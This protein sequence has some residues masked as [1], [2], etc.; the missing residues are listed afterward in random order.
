MQF[1]QN[2]PLYESLNVFCDT[3]Q[4]FVENVLFWI[5]GLME[6]HRFILLPHRRRRRPPP[7]PQVRVWRLPS[8]SL[9]VLPVSL[10]VASFWDRLLISSQ[11]L[12]SAP[13]LPTGG[14][15]Q[16]RGGGRAKSGERIS[17]NNV[18]QR[19]G[20]FAFTAKW[21][22]CHDSGRLW[23]N[24]KTRQWGSRVVCW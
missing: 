24:F 6:T 9:D 19:W 23:V 1:L 18:W 21:Q 15:P 12:G 22:K 5:S 13:W 8:R 11:W 4:C 3:W 7:R 2:M 16:L 17:W 10:C 14:R 20:S